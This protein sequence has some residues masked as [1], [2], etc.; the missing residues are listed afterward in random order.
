MKFSLVF[1]RTGDEL[2]FEVVH[3]H[4]LLAWFVDT[5]NQQTCNEFFN[6][7]G[8]AETVSQRLSQLHWAVQKTN[9]VYWLLSDQSFDQHSNLD[10]YLDQ[11]FL[12][13][14][15]SAWVQSQ[16]TVIDIDQLRFA[17]HTGKS[18]LGWN[19]H[20]LYPDGIRQIRMAQAMKK[21]GYI[22]PYEEV[23]MTVHRLESMFSKDIEYSAFDKWAGQGIDNPFLDTMVSRC[24]RV[25]FAFAY[26]FVGRQ[27]HNKWQYWD[28]DL[29]F[30]DHYNYEKLEWCFQ[31]NLDRP[32]TVEYSPE[33][34]SWAQAHQVPTI[35]TQIPI[36]NV[37]DLEKNLTHF[38]KMLYNNAR[39]HN[40]ARLFM[41]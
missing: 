9:E 18:K 21:L 25:N 2:P 39:Q 23:N 32:R 26:T 27:Y 3:N 41:T 28:T 29:E 30:S 24:D 5:A 1:D 22:F 12:N 33:F 4:D 34:L 40:A 13:R 35:T 7:D 15:H 17:H 16:S 14:Q 10:D 20:E 11:K 19:L 8:F 6:A 37:I 36:A 31:C 38:R